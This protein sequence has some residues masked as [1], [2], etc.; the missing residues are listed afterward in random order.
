MTSQFGHYALLLAFTLSLVQG[1]TPFIFARRGDVA[2]HVF[3]RRVAVAHCA[4]VIAAFAALS[5]AFATS[6]FSLALVAENSHTAKPL[7]YKFAG[8]WSNH[9]G[10]MLLWTLILALFGAYAAR[11]GDQIPGRL[12]SFALAIQA[13]ISAGFLGFILMTSNPFATLA[14][15]P[16]EG[17]GLNPILQDPGLALHPPFLYLGYVGFSMAFSFALAGLIDGGPGAA[18]ARWVRPFALAAWSF[19]T[20]GVT[21]GSFWAYYTLGWG[22]WWFWDPVENA[23]LM[24][25]LTGTAFLHSAIVMERRN[26]LAAW[27]ILLGIVTFSLSLVGTFLVR[28]GVLSSVHAFAQ[29]PSRG[30][31]IL[32]LIA[33]ATGAALAIWAW[34]APRLEKSAPFALVSRES[35]LALNNVLLSTAAFTVF[36]GTFYPL[37]VEMFGAGKISVGPP[38]FARTFAPIG[39]ILVAAAAFGPA[40]SWKRDTMRGAFARLRPA[41]LAGMV[42]LA[43]VTIFSRD[44]VAALL[45]AL[46]AWLALGSLV[47]LARRVRLFEASLLTS[48]RLARTTPQAFYGLVVAH[49]GVGVM[50]AGMTGAAFWS[51]EKTERLYPGDALRSGQVELRLDSVG[52]V[53]GPNYQAEQARFT[54]KRDGAFVARLVSERRYF[55][56]RDQTTT[57]AGIHTNL[58]ENL[59][60]ALGEAGDGGGWAVRFYRHPFVPLVWIGGL[61]MAL[62]GFVSLGDKRLRIGAPQRA[63][64]CPVGAEQWS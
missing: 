58:V 31:F 13:S 59:Y 9:E 23:S 48:L 5:Y 19:L 20:I 28:S 34:R 6:D 44:L 10:S 50:L 8:V 12:L 63:R 57:A 38:Y 36:L 40:L 2:L 39:A 61:I 60:V 42:A 55:P 30:V 41:A 26:A 14:Q 17:A 15:T 1:A 47:V 46:A 43:A 37:V 24:P 4:A 62:G 22:G 33:T 52:D 7:L 64:V 27:T 25:W 3:C 29:D 51:S 49:A 54:L 21:L 35:S 56:M 11:R 53:E 45:L 16:A 32:A 18:W